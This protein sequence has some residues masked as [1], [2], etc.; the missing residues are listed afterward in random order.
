MVDRIS[1]SSHEVACA[2]LRCSFLQAKKILSLN[3]PDHLGCE[4]A[5]CW[6]RLNCLTTDSGSQILGVD[7]ISDIE[8][9]KFEP[10][11]VGFWDDYNQTFGIIRRHHNLRPRFLQLCVRTHRSISFNEIVSAVEDPIDRF[12]QYHCSNKPS[13]RSNEASRYLA[14]WERITGQDLFFKD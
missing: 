2:T 1:V 7:M 6:H 12:A 8:V 14:I 5:K 3:E 4:V 13:S 11:L 9:A 10:I